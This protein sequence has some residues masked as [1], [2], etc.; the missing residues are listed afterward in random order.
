M[1][2]PKLS[3]MYSRLVAFWRAGVRAWSGRLDLEYWD[4][5]YVQRRPGG[6]N[7]HGNL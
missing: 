6:T 3:H 2:P 5:I 4:I 1:F 7:N